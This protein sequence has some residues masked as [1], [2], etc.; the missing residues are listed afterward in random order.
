MSQSNPVIGANKSGL[1]Y[2]QEDNDGKQALLN[3]HKGSSAPSYA[4]AGTI[5]LDDSATPWL[6]KLHDGADW[7]TLGA[8][9]AT[10]NTFVPYHGAAALR[11]VNHSSDSGAADAYAMIPTPALS[12]YVEGQIVTLAPQNANTGACTLSVSG[13]SARGIKLC[14]GADPG[15]GAMLAGG[16]YLLIYDGTYFVLL[17]PETSG[18]AALAVPTA[19]GLVIENNASTPNTKIDVSAQSAVMSQATGAPV[20]DTGLSLTVDFSASGA[21]GLDT[22]SIAA[23]SFY[24]IWL[25]SNG[26]TT[27][28][29]ASLSA[30]APT[31]PGGYGYKL[32]VGAVVTDS[33]T[34]LMR[35]RQ[36]GNAAHYV[37][38][39]STNTAAM[40]LLCSGSFG[41]TN[42]GSY[43]ATSTSG[44][45]PATAL[46][47]ALSVKSKGAT[48]GVGILLAPG[49]GYGAYNSTSNPPVFSCSPYVDAAPLVRMELESSD[50]YLATLS[51]SYVFCHG[52]TDSVNAS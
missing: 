48:E 28:A 45:V 25:I 49:P 19:S 22:G 3:H 7:I 42:T 39:P 6:L 38:T 30:T 18:G 20:F 17:N 44:V 21:N 34:V 9:S 47:I 1:T 27:A 31:L 37:V 16:I 12:A 15:A 50:V 4:E 8:V 43:V 33:S 35:T 10:A 29:L 36:A 24:H 5:W 46:S 52:W 51:H 41:N 14:S 2:R 32:R 13:L 26:S 23:S 11:M 40:P